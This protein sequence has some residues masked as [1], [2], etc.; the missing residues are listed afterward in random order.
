[1]VVMAVALLLTALTLPAMRLVH[2]NAR[3]VVCMANLQQ[4]GHAFVMYGD[5]HNDPVA[6]SI[7]GTLDVKLGGKNM[8]FYQ[9]LNG[10]AIGACTPAD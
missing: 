2:E 4:L 9:R 8:T 3:R 7:R 1:M 10:R 5:D 6:D